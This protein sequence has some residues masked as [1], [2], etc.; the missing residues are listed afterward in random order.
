MGV[1]DADTWVILWERCCAM[2]DNEEGTAMW[3]VYDDDTDIEKR[4]VV[5][6]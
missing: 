2:K 5:S 3:T 1:V 6:D 4:E